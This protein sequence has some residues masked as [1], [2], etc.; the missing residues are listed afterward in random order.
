M[1]PLGTGWMVTHESSRERP[2]I[3]FLFAHLFLVIQNQ[4]IIGGPHNYCLFWYFQECP[5]LLLDFSSCQN[6]SQLFSPTTGRHTVL[7][8]LSP[9]IIKKKPTPIRLIKICCLELPLTE[10]KTKARFNFSLSSFQLRQ[11]EH[12]SFLGILSR[13]VHSSHPHSSVGRPCSSY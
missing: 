1:S 3:F 7:S 2:H 13:R 8:P 11:K 5:S 10:I 9:G 6:H 4:A 12:T